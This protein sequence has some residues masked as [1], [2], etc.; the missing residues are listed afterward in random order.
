[1]SKVRQPSKSCLRELFDRITHVRYAVVSNDYLS[2]PIE[3]K[4]RL[5]L[6]TDN[7]QAII[8]IW[9]LTRHSP[10]DYSAVLADGSKIVVVV[11]EKGKNVFPETFETQILNRAIIHE[12]SVKIPD[13][14]TLPLMQLFW[15]LMYEKLFAEKPDDRKIMLEWVFRKTGT[16]IRTRYRWLPWNA[17]AIIKPA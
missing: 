16:P 3:I 10:E 4:G 15:K 2:L 7:L 9:N 6:L 13:S 17:A 1:M 14:E 8:N 11:L 12:N 5:I